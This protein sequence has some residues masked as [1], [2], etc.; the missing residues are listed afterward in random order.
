M[1]A[2]SFGVV[3]SIRNKKILYLRDFSPNVVMLFMNLHTLLR[4]E[5]VLK[6]VTD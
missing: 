4:F 3:Y 2:K 6:K 1:S 5:F